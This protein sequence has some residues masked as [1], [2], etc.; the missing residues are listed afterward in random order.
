[1]EIET[2][3]IQLEALIEAFENGSLTEFITCRNGIAVARLLHHAD[4]PPN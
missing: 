1:M 2:V 4:P 3:A